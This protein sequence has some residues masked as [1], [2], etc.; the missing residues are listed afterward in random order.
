MLS[1]ASALRCFIEQ[2][3]TVLLLTGAG[4][5]TE[6]GLGDYRDREGN[7]KCSPPMDGREFRRD[8]TARQRYWARSYAGWPAFSEARPNRCHNALLQLQR[9]GWADTLVTQNVD[10]LHQQA[11]HTNVIDLHGRLD[12]VVCLDCGTRESRHFFQQQLREQNP[13]Q[14]LAI[15]AL[16]PD[17]DAIV[18]SES[19]AKLQ[20]PPCQRCGGV[21][22]PDVVFFGENVPQQRVAAVYGALELA[23]GLI[24][25]GSS[26]MVYSGLRFVR[27]ALQC[28]KPVAVVNEGV[29]RA[30]DAV[31]LK[32]NL[33][34][35]PLLE[36]LL[37][38]DEVT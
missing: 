36:L 23:N 20:I 37:K 2:Q 28:G 17:G 31:N 1:G 8:A 7:W 22:K 35:A 12:T 19:I 34:I 32:L 10:G 38:S 14:N 13:D 30:D 5:S 26:L 27:R 9:R 16:R 18:D 21:I 25:F 29:T 6:S 24:V 11:G 33:R 3:Q 4:C 15:T